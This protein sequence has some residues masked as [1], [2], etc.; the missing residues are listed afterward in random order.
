[1]ARVTIFAVS[2]CHVWT[3]GHWSSR[4]ALPLPVKLGYECVISSFQEATRGFLL[5]SLLGVANVIGILVQAGRCRLWPRLQ[6]GSHTVAAA[7]VAMR[8]SWRLRIWLRLSC[9]KHM[10]QTVATMGL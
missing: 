1:V 2:V 3:A 9:R 7:M 10:H 4:A 5:Q 8:A 6:Q